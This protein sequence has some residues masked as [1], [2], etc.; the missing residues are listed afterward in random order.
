MEPELLTERADGVALLTMNRPE[1]LNALGGDMLTLLLE[2]LRELAA[3]GEI[4][5]VVLTGAGRGFS[6]GGDMKAR[7][8][9]ARPPPDRSRDTRSVS[10]RL[11]SVKSDAANARAGDQSVDA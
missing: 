2:A 11:G 5:C 4:G 6:A 10:W 8:T 1:H 7:A 3:D 9:G